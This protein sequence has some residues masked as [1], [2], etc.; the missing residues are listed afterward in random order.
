MVDLQ[1]IVR[2]CCRPWF[3][4]TSEPW[5][6]RLSK[7]PQIFQDIS[8]AFEPFKRSLSKVVWDIYLSKRFG[9]LKTLMLFLFLPL[10]KQVLIDFDAFALKKRQKLFNS[11][12]RVSET[13]K[14]LSIYKLQDLLESFTSILHHVQD[15]RIFQTIQMGTRTSK[16][17]RDV[18]KFFNF[19]K[20]GCQDLRMA[21]H[22]LEISLKPLK[23][24]KDIEPS[25][26]FKAFKILTI[27]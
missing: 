20:F 10:I 27:A 18:Q 6:T 3:K 12:T 1:K 14:V 7:L 21:F 13:L 15:S 22:T 9:A 2:T 26:V 23:G 8:K 5:A 19:S 11:I 17:V 24:V 25:K 4:V 16:G